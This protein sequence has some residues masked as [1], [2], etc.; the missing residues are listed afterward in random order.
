MD[1]TSTNDDQTTV[2]GL[3]NIN[4]TTAPQLC[5]H[6]LFENTVERYANKAAVS[7]ADTTLTY[8]QLDALANRCATFLIHQGI[9]NSDI[10]GVALERSVNLVA[11]LLAVMKT[12]A[13]YVPIDPAFP[14]ERINQMMEDARPRLLITGGKGLEAFVSWESVCLSIDEVLQMTETELDSGNP[15]VPVRGEELVY[16]MYTSGS[17]GRPKGVEVSHANVSNLLLAMQKDPGC[18]DT[19]RLLAVTTVS[20]DMAVLELFLPLICGATTIVA[21]GYE[22]RDTAALMQLMDR[23]SITIMQGTPAIWQMLLDTGLESGTQLDKI[24]CGGEALSRTLADRLLACGE[25]VWNMYGPTEATVYGSI[26]RVREDHDVIIG[27]PIING[28]LYVL[29]AEMSPV[30]LG[31]PGELYIGG[32]GVA[33]GYRNNPDLTNLRFLQ[34][35]FH[36]GMMYRTGDLACWLAPG[37]LSLMGR[38]DSQVKIRGYR[39]ELGDIEAAITTHE[40]IS[41]AVVICRDDRLVAYCVQKARISGNGAETR[42]TLGSILRPW[43]AERL[44]DYM[45]PA[46]FVEMEAFPVTING[47]IDRK[48][49]P[50]PVVTFQAA[51]DTKPATD[52]EGRILAIWTKV[53][54]HD[55]VEINDNFFEVG[56]DS[57]RVIRVQKQLEKL[58]ERSVPAPKLFEHYTIKTLASYLN[59]ST[60]NAISE[61]TF[62]RRPASDVDDIAIVSMACRLPGDIVTPE[63]FWDL[64]ERG[65]DAISIVPEG[66]WD[67]NAMTESTPDA[68]TRASCRHGGFISS[69]HDF[70][71]A[72]FGISPREAKMLDPSQYLMLETCWEGFE[73]AGYTIEQLRGSQTGVFIGTSNILA[74]QFLNPSA[75]RDLSDLDGYTVTGSAGGTLS[76]RISY[77][78]GL[79]G[80]TMT[81]DTACSSSLVTTHLACTALRQGECDM[82]I[83][84]GVSLML[85]PGLHVEFGRLQGL[86]PDGRCR[87]FGS[88]AQGTGWSE[89]S[90][91]VLLKRLSDAQRDGDKIHAVIRGTAVNHDGRSASLTTPSGTAQQRLIRGALDRSGLQPS[92]IDYVEAHG[93]GTKL[94][95]PI[96]AMALAEVFGPSRGR[97]NPLFIGSAKS[98]LG[99]TQAAAG[100]VGLLKVVLAMKNSTLPQTLYVTKPTP[101]V[102]W[103]CAN[104]M[105]VQNPQAWWSQEGRRRRAGVSAFGIGGTN[106]HAIIEESPKRA[107]TA[108]KSRASCASPLPFEM[109]FLISGDND[110]AV[111]V[112]ARKLR[113]FLDCKGDLCSLGDVA[114]SLATT[115]NHFRRR[116]VLFAES[117]S[118]LLDKLDSAVHSDHLVPTDTDIVEH[119]RIAM[120]FSGQ[121]SQWAGMGKDLCARFPIFREAISEIAAH[122]TELELP[123]L[124]V[125]W[126]EPNSPEA[127]LLSRTDFAQPALFAL[128]VSL[129]R[130]WQSWGVTPEFVLG[131]SLGELVAAHVAGIMDLPD[132]C[133]LV[134]ARSRLM[135]SQCGNHAMVSIGASAGEVE[136][137]IAELGLSDKV[138]VALFNTPAQTVI[139]G[140]AD[141]VTS[142]TGHFAGQ[143]RKIKPL[144][145]GHAF[146]SRKMDAVLS[147]LRAV[148]K[149][150][151]FHPPNLTVISSVDGLPAKAGQ[152]EQPEYWVQQVREPVRFADGIQA[153]AAQGAN[154]F[155]ELGPQPVLCGLGI[156]CLDGDGKSRSH[157]W[158]PSLVPRQSSVSTLQRSLADLHTRQ[159]LIDW[160]AVFKPFAY[161][162]VELPTYAFQRDYVSRSK[163]SSTAGKS[164]DRK[165]S[166]RSEGDTKDFKFVIKWQEVKPGNVSHRKTWGILLPGGNT[167]PWAAQV[168]SALSQAGGKLVDVDDVSDDEEL[169]GFICLWNSDTDVISRANDF[170]TQGLAQLHAAAQRQLALPLVWVTHHAVGTGIESCDRDMRLSATPLWGLMRTARSE[171]PELDLRLIDLDGQ[172]SSHVAS[173]LMLSTE[174]ECVVRQDRLLVPRMQRARPGP[175]PLSRQRLLRTDGA[176]LL[177]G[178][179]GDLGMHVARWLTS[180]HGIRDL[181]LTSRHGT[182][183]LGAADLVEELSMLGVRAT[184]I[185]SDIGDPASVKSIM[186]EFSEDRPLRGVVHAAGVTDS[187]VLAS[188]TAERCLTALVPKVYGAWLLHQATEA[189][190]LDLFMMFSSISG[191]MG[192]Q[193]LANYA[194]ANSFLDGLAHMRRAQG[195][196]ATSIAYGTWAGDGMASRLSGNTNSHLAHFGLDPI[197]PSQGLE[198]FEDAVLSNDALTV[199][200]ALDLTRL[201]RYFEEQYGIPA[202]LSSLLT[203]A[204]AGMPHVWDLGKAL[205]AANPTEHNDIMLN[206]TREVVTKVLGFAHPRD[207][208]VY[209]PLQDIGI[210]SLTA[211]QIR[212]QLAKLTGLTLS[213]NIAFLHPNLKALSEFLLSR[214]QDTDSSS[215]STSSSSETAATTVFDAPLLNMAAIREGCLDSTLMFDNVVQDPSSGGSRPASIFLTGATGFVGAFILADL[216]KQRITAHCVVRADSVESARQRLVSTLVDYGLWEPEFD[217]LIKVMVGNISQPLLGLAEETF[218]DLADRVDAICHSGA[219]VDW[220]RP[221]E[222][223]VG[224]NIVS[225]HEVLRLASRGRAKSVHLISTISTL[226]KHMGLKLVEGDQEYGYGTSKFIAE[227]LVAAARWRGARAFVYRLPY[228]TASSRTGHFRL[229]RGDFLHNL[230]AGSIQMGAFPSVEADMSAVLPVDY[231]SRSITRVMTQDLHDKG[232]D[233]DFLNTSAPTC[234]DFFRLVGDMSGGKEMT[235]FSRWKQRALDYAVVHPKSPLARIAAV[236]DNY[237]D[238]TAAGMFKGLPVGEH[239]LGSKRDPAP[240]VNEQVIRLYISRIGA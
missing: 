85:N 67:L 115:R 7:C 181:V 95:D 46:F 127:L 106:A 182:Q 51:A 83:S 78:L 44:P 19:D 74:H 117:K 112:Q 45:L 53:L 49:L 183:A 69:I 40:R 207:V 93:T 188:M 113:D 31:T 224:P 218:E 41:G 180:Q 229:D 91:V 185:A 175:K 223:Y 215:A 158:L 90:V 135:Q 30:Q 196:P 84:G 118:Q 79:E 72:F 136:E 34:N 4:S 75:S 145:T 103:Q 236:L 66:R 62:Q 110:A 140:D 139:S 212:N 25:K 96:E 147:D 23:H 11:I 32:A 156:A 27:G 126:A 227:R 148:A 108:E 198:L 213:V 50:D 10:I 208:D 149:T 33:R 142:L 189:M 154:T 21:Q 202:L 132:A 146:H 89:G 177:T 70:D 61:P 57:L 105:P 235:S 29:D 6:Q 216:L 209:R 36:H 239:V 56:G 137:A 128:E 111:R 190:D 152:L 99:H 125:M 65:G 170:T 86:S 52:L 191:V 200:A 184:V 100:L 220:M 35:P 119:P 98:N 63:E 123:L 16:I 68:Q 28:H 205:S 171:H 144:V 104:M 222:E 197:T 206:T 80:P 164:S 141:A 71:A 240:T 230:I 231:L 116:R 233:F 82:A 195:L 199:A 47:K 60:G 219:L 178:G 2:E 43:L 159:V 204:S 22:I 157:F 120:L 102:D 176:V 210:D 134:A 232:R 24:F 5:V 18:R 129:W 73:R 94:G 37:K 107:A 138:D 226:P 163:E 39:I 38:I 131:H 130:L 87:A 228:V 124:D 179:L 12:G 121:G 187:G 162:R 101:A 217:S 64:L 48:A 172:T 133:R 8:A 114:H 214:L 155:L 77:H 9:G 193:G 88:E 151:R 20:F 122:F 211:V 26:W 153:L 186:A 58:L 76:G 225:T 14:A 168:K 160:L 42:A 169:D 13:T 167:E 55:R 15:K 150:V 109:P 203:R 97:T 194:A 3:G 143:G 166:R 234:N 173:A 161:Q 237:T 165:P 59:R 238:E 221:L 192:M 174:P 1:S 54:G 17:T 201:Q 92:D 81:I